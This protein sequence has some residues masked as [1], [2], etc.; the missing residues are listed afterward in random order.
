MSRSRTPHRRQSKRRLSNR[1]EEAGESLDSPYSLY[2]I[3]VS[4]FSTEDVEDSLNRLYKKVENHMPVPLHR[5][6]HG[7]L[8]PFGEGT[9]L[10]K[11]TGWRKGPDWKLLQ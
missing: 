2:A 10:L 4:V 9:V 11:Y 1:K 5:L 6:G 3:K 7:P 8:L